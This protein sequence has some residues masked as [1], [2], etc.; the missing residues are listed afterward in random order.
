MNERTSWPEREIRTNKLEQPA[1]IS[2]VLAR[3]LHKNGSK[4]SCSSP[5]SRSAVLQR[6]RR[7]GSLEGSEIR[8][9]LGLSAFKILQGHSRSTNR[10]RRLVRRV[11]LGNVALHQRR[12]G[13]DAD[14]V[15]VVLG[16][17]TRAESS[18]PQAVEHG[19][20]QF[21]ERGRVH[22]VQL[23]LVAVPER[24]TASSVVP[25]IGTP[26]RLLPTALH[27]PG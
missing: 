6:H 2:T 23:V 11:S 3:F 15:V 9:T 26:E 25:S 18:R 17:A 5:A 13:L 20:D 7:V 19:P 12:V 27:A 16:V 22:R 24:A 14:A 21:A 1:P 8:S 10:R 4:K